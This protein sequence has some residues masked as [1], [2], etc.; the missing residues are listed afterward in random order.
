[1]GNFVLTWIS[2]KFI[3]VQIRQLLERFSAWRRKGKRGSKGRKIKRYQI[4]EEAM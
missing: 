3:F 4:V 2:E 1:M